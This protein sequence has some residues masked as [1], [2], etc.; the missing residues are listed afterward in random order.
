M[1]LN[2]RVNR[3]STECGCKTMAKFIKCALLSLV[4]AISTATVTVTPAEANP[5][6]RNAQATLRDLCINLSALEQL[7]NIFG[8][9]RNFLGALQGLLDGIF[10]PPAINPGCLGIDPGSLPSFDLAGLLSCLQNSIQVNPNFQLNC[11]ANGPAITFNNPRNCINFP[12]LDLPNLEFDLATCVQPPIFDA[13]GVLQQIQALLEGLLDPVLNF[14]LPLA[15]PTL[16]PQLRVVCRDL[17]LAGGRS[18]AR[19]KITTR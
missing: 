7:L 17:G 19:L 4:V 10:R 18:R 16:V 1:L 14:R 12:N 5:R 8:N 11:S 2:E 13:E 3:S 15:F 9:L 6:V